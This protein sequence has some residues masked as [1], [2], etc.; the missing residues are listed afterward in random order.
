MDEC[1][2]AQ[3][4]AQLYLF[5]PHR[6]THAEIERMWIR[7]PIEA[8]VSESM[9]ARFLEGAAFGPDEI[10][11]WSRHMRGD[12]SGHNDPT[13]E[14]LAQKIVMLAKQGERDPVR[15]Q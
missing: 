2:S 14:S 4:C 11:I 9:L 10:A 1:A 5:A 15:L 12:A 7:L 6:D 8:E 13:A 3:A